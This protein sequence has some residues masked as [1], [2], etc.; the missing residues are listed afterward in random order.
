MLKFG[1]GVT[2][3]KV[4]TQVLNGFK[5]TGIYYLNHLFLLISD[6]YFPSM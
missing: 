1:G 4:K 6:L 2:L 3:K 5:K